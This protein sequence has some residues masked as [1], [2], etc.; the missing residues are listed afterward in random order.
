[1]SSRTTLQGDRADALRTRISEMIEDAMAAQSVSV[2]ALARRIGHKP[3]RMEQMLA[4]EGSTL[5]MP[6]I[7]RIADVL[8]CDLV[9]EFK[10]RGP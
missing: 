8:D 1:M 6:T 5:T 9:L 2:A 4:Q 3:W 7:V 10:K